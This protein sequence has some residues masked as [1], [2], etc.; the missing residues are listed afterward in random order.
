MVG[1]DGTSYACVT[2]PYWNTMSQFQRQA[3][4]ECNNLLDCCPI[5]TGIGGRPGAVGTRTINGV[6]ARGQCYS[7]NVFQ[8]FCD[9]NQQCGCVPR[10]DVSRMAVPTGSSFVSLFNMITT[11]KTYADFVSSLQRG[12]HNEVHAAMGGLMSTFASPADALFFNWHGTVDMLMFLWHNCHLRTGIKGRDAFTSEYAFNQEKECRNQRA[13]GTVEAMT[14]QTDIFMQVNGSDIRNHTVLGRYFQDVGTAYGSFVDTKE[15]GDYSYA[16]RVPDGFYRM[17]TDSSQCASAGFINWP[18][19]TEDSEE[20]GSNGELTYWEWYD[21]TRAVLMERYNNDTEEV[22][23]QL[24]YLECMGF[25]EKFGVQAFD[26]EFVDDFLEGQEIEPRCQAILEKI[27]NG[28][29]EVDKDLVTTWGE[30]AM[31]NQE[32]GAQQMSAAVV[33][34]T[35]IVTTLVCSTIF[36]VIAMA[37]V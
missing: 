28:T 19:P 32:L 17:L 6:T 3:D 8:N 35:S 29:A 5:I 18:A 20:A 14:A 24:E 7:G 15:M 11:H 2:L 33:L 1:E 31:G 36:G 23:R 21:Q 26:K 37:L 34:T 13:Q 16:Y 10:R 27:E 25:D 12:V 30:A 22:S 4:G 9:D